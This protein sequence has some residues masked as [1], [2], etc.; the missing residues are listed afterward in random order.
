MY[1]G[2]EEKMKKTEKFKKWLYDG[3]PEKMRYENDIIDE[4]I[5]EIIKNYQSKTSFQKDINSVNIKSKIKN[6][7]S[8]D[9]LINSIGETFRFLPTPKQELTLKKG[10]FFRAIPRKGIEF[11]EEFKRDSYYTYNNQTLGRFNDENQFI[12]YTSN[13]CKSALGECDLKENDNYSLICY[14]LNEKDIL[15]FSGIGLKTQFNKGLMEFSFNKYLELLCFSS[16]N[17][18]IEEKTKLYKLT[19]FYRSKFLDVKNQENID[20]FF[21][22][23]SKGM[24]Q[25]YNCPDLTLAIKKSS[26]NKLKP[27]YV[28]INSLDNGK[29]KYIVKEDYS[30]QQE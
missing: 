17:L 14:E 22:K 3:I 21:I 6:S 16:N 1:V 30:L 28:V 24:C 11:F 15:N 12:L 5:K 10:Y 25:N 19:N 8:I 9:Y 23:S 26:E 7:D 2:G 29:K 13:C 20:G 18:S 4:H 27:K